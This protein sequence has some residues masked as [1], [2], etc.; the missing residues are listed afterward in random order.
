M[1]F[2]KN[3]DAEILEILKEDLKETS[4]LDS[5]TTQA[6]KNA[7]EAVKNLDKDG[8]SGNNPEFSKDSE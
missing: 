1:A 6:L 4:S 8:S 2:V 3:G 5:S 7:K